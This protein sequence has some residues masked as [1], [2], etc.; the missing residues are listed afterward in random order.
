MWSCAGSS[1]KSQLSQFLVC[2]LL[3]VSSWQSD[4]DKRNCKVDL[5]QFHLVTAS[6]FKQPVVA[7][8]TFFL[9]DKIFQVVAN[10]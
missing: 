7:H 8:S 10:S 2:V 6:N 4:S 9:G 5:V 3:M 1:S